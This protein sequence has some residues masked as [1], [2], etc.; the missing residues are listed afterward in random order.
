MNK[1]ILEG[2]VIERFALFDNCGAV[3]LVFYLSCMKYIVWLLIILCLSGCFRR[4][5]CWVG[6]WWIGEVFFFVEIFYL[7]SMEIRYKYFNC[8]YYLYIYRRVRSK[9]KWIL[10]LFNNEIFLVDIGIVKIILVVIVFE[11]TN[12]KG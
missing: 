5:V 2:E 10:I 6:V 3:V 9:N 7:F 4:D 1:C 12:Y 11:L 8:N